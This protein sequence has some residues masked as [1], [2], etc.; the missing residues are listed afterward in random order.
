M[1]S[2]TSWLVLG[3][4]V[5]GVASFAAAGRYLRV[6]GVEAEQRVA[7]RYVQRQVLVVRQAVDAGM[8]LSAALLATRSVPERYL[9][10]DALDAAAAGSVLGARLVHG[11]HAGEVVT[12]SAL[13]SASQV[14]LSALIEPG[15]RAITIAVDELSSSDGLLV[16]GDRIDLLYIPHTGSDQRIE[17]LLQGAAVVATGHQLRREQVHAADGSVQE[18]E[19]EFG[20]ITLHVAARDA[21]KIALAQRAGELTAMLRRSDDGAAAPLGA[22]SADA[23]LSGRSGGAAPAMRA[24]RAAQHVDFIIGGQGLE[25]EIRSAALATAT[26]EH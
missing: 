21:E 23:L 24:Q 6:R 18:A 9:A 14:A 10:G 16:P 12:R 4:V 19:R 7:E 22:L 1:T 20:T 25:P 13:Q 11:L 3:A 17:P 26:Q 15:S 2:R 5:T 8:T